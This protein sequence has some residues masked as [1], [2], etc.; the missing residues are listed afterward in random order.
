MTDVGRTVEHDETSRRYALVE[1]GEQ[2][3]I[4]DYRLESDG[5]TAVFH[6]TV[7]QPARRGEGLAA[8]LVRAAM[9]D[10]RRRGWRVVATC[11][12]VDGFLR[13]HPEYA[14]LRAT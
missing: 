12:Y 6:H 8:E 14:D 11:W 5:V 3:T 10:V 9:D 13:D 1:D 7:T 2:L 4:A